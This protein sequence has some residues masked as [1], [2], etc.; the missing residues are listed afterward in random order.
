MHEERQGNIP[1]SF[2]KIVALCPEIKHSLKAYGADAEEPLSQALELEFPFALGFICRTHIV[3]NLE[4]KLKTELNLSDKFLRKV[5]ADVFGGKTQEGLVH[6]SSRQE[7]DLLA[8]LSV[9]WDKDEAEER[10]RKRDK[11][12]P[13]A[14]KYFMKNKAEIV[15]HHCRSA[16][17]REVDIDDK[18][19]DNNDPESINALIK[20]RENR[21]KSDIPKFVTDM[22][23][24]HDK[25]MTFQEHSVV[26][27]ACIQSRRVC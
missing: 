11:Q 15:Y 7:Y 2:Q 27:L 16:A 14:S 4:H 3:R 13:M 6:C 23:E 26:H 24:L 8:K 19:F 12:E 22:K 10:A 5:V 1:M 9:K 21:A 18:L 20:K 25:G 17:L